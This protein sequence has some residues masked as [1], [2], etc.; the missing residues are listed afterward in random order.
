MK[1]LKNIYAISLILFQSIFTVDSYN[2]RQDEMTIDH[3]S[4]SILLQRHTIIEGK[5]YEKNL[6]NVFIL[7]SFYKDKDNQPTS[8][9]EGSLIKKDLIDYLNQFF[10]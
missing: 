4:A 6:L 5:T 3:L 1:K 8:F 7:D 9:P 10:C 2:V